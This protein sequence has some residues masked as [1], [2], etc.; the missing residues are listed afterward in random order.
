M[1]SPCA[2]YL[3]AVTTSIYSHAARA[4]SVQLRTAGFSKA[5]S[6]ATHLE[7]NNR[8]RPFE[9][10]NRSSGKYFRTIED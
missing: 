2:A 10:Q 9:T 1:K 6:L 8:L 5:P 3:G 7:Y 4:P